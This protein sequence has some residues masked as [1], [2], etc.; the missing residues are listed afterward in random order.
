MRRLTWRLVVAF[1]LLLACLSVAVPEP[2]AAQALRK[3][4]SALTPT[5]LMS[6]RR[7]VSVMMARN[8]APRGSADFRRSWIYWANMHA[9]FGSSCRGPIKGGSMTG[10][11]LWVASNPTETA[12]WCKCEHGTDQFLTWHRMYVWYFERVLQQAAND[13]ALRL[14][15]WDYTSNPTLPAAFRDATYVNQAGQT[16]PN[17]LRVAA[18]NP[19][20]NN[21]SAGL[22]AGTVSTSNAMAATGYTAFRSRLESGP[23]GAVH[24]SV[25]VGGCPNG[26]MGG[27]ASAALDPI[28]YLHHSNIDRLYECWLKVNESARLPSNATLLNTSFSFIDSDGSMKTRRVRDM[29]RTAQL[30]YGYTSGG[31]CP[32]AAPAAAVVAENMGAMAM[33][34]TELQR[35]VTELSIGME[36]GGAAPAAAAAPEAPAAVRSATVII[37]GFT[38]AK[39]PGILFNVYLA[40]DQGRREQVGVIDFFGFDDGGA[41]QGHGGHG[42][43][44]RFEF[45]ATAAVATLG[46][47]STRSPKLVFEPTTGLTDSTLEAATAEIPVDAKVSFRRAWLQVDK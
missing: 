18:R 43:G 8:S 6:L 16:V 29:L 30:G 42:G 22:A 31:G 25:A 20:L 4:I 24:C 37:E 10:L 46:L 1:I 36:G 33:A 17:P 19:T 39:V 40:N 12:T 21:G 3:S 34:P 15:Y 28:F 26:L 9:H 23:H 44:R 45:D 11:Q 38:A 32:A 5:E 2:A 47:V 13:P 27:Q 35:G 7:G 14:P 41:M